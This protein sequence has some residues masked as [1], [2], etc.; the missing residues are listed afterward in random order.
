MAKLQEFKSE[1]LRHVPEGESTVSALSVPLLTV[2][3]CINFSH[4]SSSS[5]MRKKVPVGPEEPGM[6]PTPSGSGLFP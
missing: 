6:S 1:I 5:K 4:D 2:L 3:P